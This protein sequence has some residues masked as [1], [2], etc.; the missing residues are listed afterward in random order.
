MRSDDGQANGNGESGLLFDFEDFEIEKEDGEFG[1]E[2]CWGVEE[3][4]D[5]VVLACVSLFAVLDSGLVS[6]YL[7][8]RFGVCADWYIP[9]MMAKCMLADG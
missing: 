2:Y 6:T 5:H 1:E 7:D 8:R 9:H 3:G 4:Q